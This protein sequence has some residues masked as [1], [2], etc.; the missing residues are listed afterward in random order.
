MI[1]DLLVFDDI[2]PRAPGFKGQEITY[3][4]NFFE[5]LIILVHS[6]SCNNLVRNI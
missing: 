2:E 4:E 3:T 6:S 1:D 5:D